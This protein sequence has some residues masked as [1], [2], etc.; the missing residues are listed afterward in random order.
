MIDDVP[1][2]PRRLDGSKISAGPYRFGSSREV[3]VH[4]GETLTDE[5]A[6]A[7]GL[8]WLVEK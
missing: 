4:W 8:H 5:E 3:F 1:F 6:K 2:Y 7:I